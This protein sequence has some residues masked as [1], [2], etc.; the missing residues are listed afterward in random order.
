MTSLSKRNPVSRSLREILER[1]VGRLQRYHVSFE[2]YA[3][4]LIMGMVGFAAWHSGANLLYLMFAMMIGFFLVQGIALWICLLGVDVTRQIPRTATALEEI[5]LKFSVR[6]RKRFL[7]SFGLRIVDYLDRNDPLGAAFVVSLRRQS[8]TETI[9]RA[10]FPRRGLVT[11]KKLVVSSRYPFGLAQRS[12]TVKRKDHVLIF[13]PAIDVRAV[14]AD[15]RVE[16]GEHESRRKGIG[17]E[18]F[19]LKEYVPGDQVRHIHWRSSAKAQRLMTMEYENEERQKIS[20]VLHNRVSTDELRDSAV[21]D[22]FEKALTFVASFCRELIRGGYEVQLVTDSGI[23]PF[24]VGQRHLMRLL[25]ACALLELTTEG[26]VLRIPPEAST[27]HFEVLFFSRP[28]PPVPGARALD[29]R[30]WQVFERRFVRLSD[31][32]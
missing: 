32:A 20:I 4:I 16:F 18:F 19:G 29:V 25:R 3:F 21:R 31:A 15:L 14:V 6:N 13:P 24:G 22:E 2:G 8:T 17:S 10:V 7:S 11:L 23:V 12:M 5:E 1:P 27:V 28:V 9:Y 30:Q 26:A